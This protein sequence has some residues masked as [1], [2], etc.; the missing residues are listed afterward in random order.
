MANYPTCHVQNID[1]L[2]LIAAIFK[3]HKIVERI[4][5]LLPKTSNNQKITHGEA[6]LAMVM[7]GLDFTNHRLYMSRSFFTSISMLG[8]FR[9]DVKPEHFTYDTFGRALDA[10]Y[11][12]GA[13]RLFIDICL[14]VILKNKILTK[15][16]FMDTTSLY[17]TGKKYKKD[18][19]IELKHGHSKD[20]RKDL[21]Q[22]VYLLI[23]TEDGVPFHFEGHSGN[24]NDNELFQNAIETVQKQLK[25]SLDKKFWVLDSSIYSKKFIENK[26]ITTSWIA[27]VPESIKICREAVEKD[28]EDDAWT[29][30][31]NDYKY[32]ELNAN[33]GGQEQ[34]WILVSNRCSKYGEL[35]NFSKKIDAQEKTLLKTADKAKKRLFASKQEAIEEFKKLQKNH[36]S[37]ILTDT[38]YAKKKRI[39]GSKRKITAGYK[40]IV[41]VK[42]NE[43]RIKK[44][45]LKKGR[46]VLA[47]NCLENEKIKAKEILSAYRARNKGVEGCFKFIKDRQ[48]NLNQIYLKKESRIEAMLMVMSLTLFTNNLAQRK[49][50]DFLKEQK[51]GVYSQLGRTTQSPTF[52]WASMVMRNITRV[53]I[54]VSGTVHNMVK[55]IKKDQETI[56]KAFGPYAM[57]IYGIT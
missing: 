20:Y 35:A 8:L 57:E 12:Y 16:I 27:R 43:D 19:K 54:I 42:R 47:T 49:L 15:F 18:G 11:K 23:S 3:Q 26:S 22:L 5:S 2:G 13:T 7:Q 6:I 39:R 30:M 28:Y 33:Y 31:D 38:I 29:R 46:F 36:P 17:V 32:I 51:I 24:K 48:N 1:H 37:F 21:K 25:S 41:K 44:C 56:I 10:I 14:D 34:R 9:P 52:K 40:L 4:D 50:R 45:E 55:G 53:K